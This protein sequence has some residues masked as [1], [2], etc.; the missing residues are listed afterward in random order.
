MGRDTPPLSAKTQTQ[1]CLEFISRIARILTPELKFLVIQL[2]LQDFSPLPIHGSLK[3]TGVASVSNETI[4]R[5]IWK[6][7]KIAQQLYRL[8]RH[9]GKNMLTRGAQNAGRGCILGR[10]DIDERLIAEIGF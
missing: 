1:K 3:K 10:V 4:C 5:L 9:R 8:M 7:K 2:I 6:D